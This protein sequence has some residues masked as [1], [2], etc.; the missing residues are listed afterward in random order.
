[1]VLQVRLMGDNFGDEVACILR[2]F[3]KQDM[4]KSVYQKIS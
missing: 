2:S 1:M 4:A 3:N